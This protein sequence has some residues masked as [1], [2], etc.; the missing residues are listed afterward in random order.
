[1]RPSAPRSV[2][3]RQWRWPSIAF[4][5]AGFVAAGAYAA[6]VS[7]LLTTLSLALVGLGSFAALL[8]GP[9]WH[10]PVPRRPWTF[11]TAAA[12]LFLVGTLVRGWAVNQHGIVAL[13]ADFFTVPGYVFMIM[14]LVGLIRARRSHERDAVL[15]V[16]IIGGAASVATILLLSSPAAISTRPVVVSI[17]AVGYPLFDIVVLVLLV[18]LAFTTAVRQPSYLLLV[19]TI[20]MLLIGDLAYA[21]IGHQGPARRAPPASTCRSCSA[22]P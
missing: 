8:I 22:S 20:T 18:N 15:D 2:G 7:P 17:L 5:V 3:G 9:S 16:L 19:G 10:R 13:A 11:L 21:I 6:D 1:M 4:L 14:A 12:G